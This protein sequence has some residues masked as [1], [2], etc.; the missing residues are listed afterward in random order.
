M[1]SQALMLAIF[2]VSYYFILSG[3]FKSSVMVFLMGLIVAFMK[4]VEDMSLENLSQFIDFNTI[5]L[6]AGMMIIVGLLKSTGFFQFVAVYAV[7]MGRGDIRKTLSLIVISIALLSAFLDNVT[8]ILIFAPILLFISDTVGIDAKYLMVTGIIASNLGGASTMIGDPPNI[9]I[10]SAS[11]LS[12]NSFIIHLAPV[13]ILIL[14]LMLFIWFR[15]MNS[16]E[17]MREKIKKLATTDPKSAII[18]KK[19]MIALL[20][21]FL[22]VIFGFALHEV[23]DYEMALISMAGA[24]IALV[25]YGKSF[26]EAAK[27][28][29]WDTLFFLIGLFMITYAMRKV[30]LIDYL[31][32]VISKV[33]SPIIL[34]TTL[35]WFSGILAMFLSAVPTVII[36]IPVVQTLLLMGFTPVI[37][38]AL[39]LGASLGANGTTIGAAVNIVGVSL[40]GKYGGGTVRFVSYMKRAAP[41][42]LLM[43]LIANIYVIF[44]YLTGW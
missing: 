1:F 20:F 39:S 17:S 9:I 5:G 3:R 8:T 25:I 42:T 32:N 33:H 34:M 12:F 31:T 37:W 4:I 7:K 10:G 22:G 26:E 6:L 11:K 36:M 23:L 21:V 28:V 44:I 43:L 35:I 27:E 19:K 15:K 24:T 18:D 30:G 13:C 2:C 16:D 41:I 29:E 14:M 38:W 40:L